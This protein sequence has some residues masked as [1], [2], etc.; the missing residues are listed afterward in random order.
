MTKI[1]RSLRDATSIA[2]MKPGHPTGAVEGGNHPM[3]ALTRSQRRVRAPGLQGDRPWFVG[4][5]T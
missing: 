1:G 5:K 4:A 2:G 3:L